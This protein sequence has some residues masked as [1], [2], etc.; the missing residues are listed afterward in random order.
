MSK[1]H[2]HLKQ[3]FMEAYR[4]YADA[5]YRYCILR[6]GDGE[7]V[8]DM[9]QDV[10]MKTWDYMR[11]G[12]SIVN[13][14]AFLYTTAG[15]LVIDE[16]RKR[17]PIESLEILRE[18]GFEPGFDETERQMDKIDGTQAITL[19]SSLPAKYGEAI[20]LRY[21]DELSL[22][23]MSEILGESENTLAVRVHR[24]IALL[25]KVFNHDQNEKA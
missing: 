15:R 16:Y 3:E 23:E 25:R 1:A 20:Y 14:R 10:F 24:G 6:L 11:S 9:V 2:D 12:Q 17:K 19:L 22:S 13:M 4:L 5:I 21:V 18:D 8:C 7:R